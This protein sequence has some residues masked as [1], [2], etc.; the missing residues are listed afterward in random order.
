VSDL[1]DKIERARTAGDDA[2]LARLLVGRAAELGDTG[3]LR[4]A[5]RDLDEAAELHGRGGRTQ[6]Q[7]RCLHSAATLCRAQGE[8]DASDERARAAEELAEPGT[9]WK[10]AALIEQGETAILRGDPEL[11]YD[12]YSAALDHGR[13]A[14]LKQEGQAALLRKRARARTNVAIDDQVVTD[15]REAAALYDGYGE[16]REALRTRVEEATALYQLDRTDELEALFSEL[17]QAAADQNQPSVLADLAFLLTTRAVEEQDAETALTHA[18]AAR[19]HALAATDPAAYIASAVA[20][21]QLCERNGDRVGAYESLAVGWV[22]LGDLSDMKSA[23]EIFRPKLLELKARW[24][25][26]AFAA[27]KAEYEQRRLDALSS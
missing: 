6:E 10:V 19:K 2:E 7:A 5:Q 4:E 18:R 3:K 27:V 17:E 24:G 16:Q 15:L 14:G 12:R 21:A 9:P 8:L 22:T 23:G 25:D 20:I 13:Q 26:D 11:A 1:A